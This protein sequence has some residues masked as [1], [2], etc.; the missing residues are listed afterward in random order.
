MSTTLLTVSGTIPPDIA[1]RIARGER[2]RA[3]YLEMA[4]AFDADLIDY[5]EARRGSG[6]FGRLLERLAGA[7]VLLA[8]ACWQR[9]KQYQAIF[10][11]GEQ[12]GLPYA[13]LSKLARLGFGKRPRHLM[14]VHILSVPKKMLFLDLLGLQSDIDTFFVYATWQKHFIQERWRISPASVV[15]TPFMVDAD[16]F[17]PDQVTPQSRSRPLVC[18]VGLEARDYPTMLE[19]VEGLPADFCIAAAS[20]WSKR[21]DNTRGRAIPA[22]VQVQRF[23]QYDLR[24]LYADSSFMVMP[25]QNVNFQA[26]VTAIL[27]AMAMG[28]AVV[29]SRT[30]GQTDVVVNGET[31]IYV[32]PDDP[33]ALRQVIEYLLANPQEAARMG[34]AG[35]RRVLESMDLNSYVARLHRYVPALSASVPAPMEENITL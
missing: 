24:Q 4:R 9:R 21:R 32:P 26:G 20:P 13:L 33:A 1:E 23:S 27:E 18:S 8:Y 11:D 25:L 10:T 16:F 6:P 34:Q 30:P 31:G 2:P 28:K 22:N 17:A 15:F 29:C 19:A 35:R 14:I 3:D 5:A 7:D 12:I